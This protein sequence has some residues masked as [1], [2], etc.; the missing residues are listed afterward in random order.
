MVQSLVCSVKP[1]LS[2]TGNVLS[3]ACENNFAK[4]SVAPLFN[5]I[6]TGKFESRTD[7]IASSCPKS[8]FSQK[9]SLSPP[10]GSLL[11]ID[12]SKAVVLV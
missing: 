4:R 3:L 11:A 10:P 5:R 6:S 8:L 1:F 9:L 2:V 7:E 12:R